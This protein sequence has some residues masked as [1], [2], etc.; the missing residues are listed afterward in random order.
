MIMPVPIKDAFLRE[1]QSVSAQAEKALSD[2]YTGNP[3]YV[4][5]LTQQSL[6]NS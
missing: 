6:I 5:H 4:T 2:V 3:S 1:V